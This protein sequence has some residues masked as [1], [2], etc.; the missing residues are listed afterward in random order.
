MVY[1]QGTANQ[2]ETLRQRWRVGLID[3]VNAVR[4]SSTVSDPFGA[5]GQC[6]GRNIPE[7]LPADVSSESI[8]DNAIEACRSDLEKVREGLSVKYG[9]ARAGS[10][11]ERLRLEIR[12]KAIAMI[13]AKRQSR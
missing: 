1:G 12:G 10:D 9:A 4:N 3:H 8:A 7:L 6:V 5:W 2:V 13:N 11:I